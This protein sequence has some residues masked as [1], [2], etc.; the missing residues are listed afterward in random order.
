[1]DLF[2]YSFFITWVCTIQND[3]CF[4]SS[5]RYTYVQLSSFVIFIRLI[6]SIE[7]LLGMLLSFDHLFLIFFNLLFQNRKL[8]ETYLPG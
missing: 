1:M 2:D 3:I 8:G 5:D 6:Y 4:M 7:F